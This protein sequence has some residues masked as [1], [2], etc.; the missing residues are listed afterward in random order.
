[1][2]YWTDKYNGRVGKLIKV[3]IIARI[4]GMFDIEL[5]MIGGT[6]RQLC[7]GTLEDAH[8]VAE[9]LCADELPVVRDTL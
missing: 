8:D 2:I 7:G 6:A 4:D 9:L 5:T 3:Y 1:M